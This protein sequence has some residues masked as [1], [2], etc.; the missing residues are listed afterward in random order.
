MMPIQRSPD[1]RFPVVVDNI[2]YAIETSVLQTAEFIDVLER[3]TLALR[4]PVE[5]LARVDA[6]VR[7]ANLIVTARDLNAH[8]SLVGVSRNVTDFAFCCYCSDLAVDRSYQGRG[9]GQVLLEQTRVAAGD[10]TSL[11]LFAAPEAI[12][13][14]DHI[15]VPR[16]PNAFGFARRAGSK[17]R[18]DS[19]TTQR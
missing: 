19:A 6:M 18:E 14:Y 16:I 2:E 1:A 9:I 11:Y 10:E 3:S 12:S 15:G 4:R 13:F 17:A 8:S 5:D 7:N